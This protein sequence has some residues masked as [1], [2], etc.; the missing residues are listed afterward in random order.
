[1][2]PHLVFEKALLDKIP[3]QF[4]LYYSDK[5]FFLTGTMDS[6]IYDFPVAY[7]FGLNK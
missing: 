4:F 6:D 7:S 2:K 1:M 5:V 3:S